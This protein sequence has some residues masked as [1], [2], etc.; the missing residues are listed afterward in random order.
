MNLLLLPPY[1]FPFDWKNPWGYLIA[2]G[3][4]YIGH[5]YIL[6]VTAC[7]LIYGIGGY[8]LSIALSKSIKVN[9]Y[10]INQNAGDENHRKYL[11]EQ[12]IEFFECHSRM[13]QLSGK[14]A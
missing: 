14:T 8:M 6:L 9:L 3:I 4:Q 2:V 12:F 5:G 10:S 11:M 13:K 7:V 1:R